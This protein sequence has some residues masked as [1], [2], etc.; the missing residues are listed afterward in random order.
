MVDAQK[1]ILRTC[2]WTAPAL[3]SRGCSVVCQAAQLQEPLQEAL[4]TIMAQA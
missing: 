1:G 3:P 4:E 2:R